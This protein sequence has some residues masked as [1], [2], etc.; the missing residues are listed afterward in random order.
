MEFGCVADVIQK[1]TSYVGQPE[2]GATK[3]C[4]Y[5]VDKWEKKKSVGD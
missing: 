1:T 5:V 4:M 2:A 3:M